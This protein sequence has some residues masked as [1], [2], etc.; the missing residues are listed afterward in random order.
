ME[1]LSGNM[2][3]SFSERLSGMGVACLLMDPEVPKCKISKLL[4]AVMMT[5]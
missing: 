4:V 5:V 2:L 1:A 3:L